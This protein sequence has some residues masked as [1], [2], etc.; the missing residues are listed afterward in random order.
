MSRDKV[1]VARKQ[2]ASCMQIIKNW[3]REKG[4]S[5]TKSEKDLQDIGLDKTRDCG[6]LF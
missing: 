6:A 1:P 2:M 5:N 4:G 3:K